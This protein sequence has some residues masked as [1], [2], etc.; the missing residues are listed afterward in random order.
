MIPELREES[1]DKSQESR[2]KLESRDKNQEPN[3]FLVFRIKIT[4]RN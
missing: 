3:F 2:L 4:A 1:R